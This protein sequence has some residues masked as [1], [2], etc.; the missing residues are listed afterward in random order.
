MFK[1]V[2][3]GFFPQQDT[4]R[5]NGFIQAD[6]DTS[7]QEMSKKM[8]EFVDIVGRT[9]R[10]IPSPP[11]PAGKRYQHRTHVAHQPLA[12][13]KIDADHIIARLRDKTSGIP[14]ASL[15]LQSVQTT[16]GGRFGGAQHNTRCRQNLT[17]VTLAPSSW[18]ACGRF[19][20]AR[21]QFRPA[22]Q[23][24][25]IY[26]PLTATPRAPGSSIQDIDNV[27]DSF[28][29]RQVSNIYKGLNQYHVVLKLR[30]NF[31]RILTLKLIYAPSKS[32]NL[33]R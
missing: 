28:G 12:E 22:E 29:Q 30:R 19:R 1:H 21:Y 15:F 3:K 10:L 9:P 25:A 11:S 33:F 17:S 7:F 32:G 2:N 27:L 4:G 14:G 5:I 16:V 8:R 6:Q 18:I 23:G 24:A 13:R 26:L 31:S 20:T